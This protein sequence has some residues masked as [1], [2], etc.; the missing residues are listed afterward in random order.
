L[1]Q[2]HVNQNGKVPYEGFKKDIKDLEKHLQLLSQETPQKGWTVDNKMAYWINAY[3]TFTIKYMIQNRL[4]YFQTIS[5]P[6]AGITENTA[7]LKPNSI[8]D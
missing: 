3:N 2:K 1:L 8:L 7:Y 5:S 6:Q 4:M